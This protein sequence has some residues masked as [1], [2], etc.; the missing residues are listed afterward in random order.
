MAARQTRVFV[1]AA[2]PENDWAETLIG[3]LIRPLTEEF[4]E[5]LDWFW[6][7]RYG[8]SADDSGDCD[9]ARIPIE[10]K[11]APDRDNAGF[12]RS[13]RFRYA[14]DNEWQVPFE[15]RALQLITENSYCISDFR[16]YDFI[17]DTGNNRFL[18]NENRLPGRA[19]QRAV[20]VTQFY[21]VISRLVID[22]LVGPDP[23]N[24]F[25]IET[26]DDLIQN[27]AGST[28][29]SLLHLFCNITK[30]PTDVYVFRKEGLNILGFGTYIYPPPPPSGDWDD[31]TAY[32]IWF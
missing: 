15:Q 23:S 17:G 3:K 1:P 26:N 8:P 12:H 14:I 4:A 29:Q 27:P 11:Q 2:E 19:R 24:R 7:S 25:R 21:M 32:P 30:A 5:H 22:A 10:Y 13:L 9:I 28:F 20:L 18:G 16:P 6:F 31:S